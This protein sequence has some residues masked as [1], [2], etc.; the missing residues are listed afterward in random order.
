[1]F[2]GHEEIAL[3]DSLRAELPGIL[4]W[5]IDGWDRLRLRGRFVQPETSAELVGDMADLASPVALGP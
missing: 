3:A 4:Q 1:M 2:Y 5:S